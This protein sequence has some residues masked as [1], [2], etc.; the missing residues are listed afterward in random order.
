[1]RDPSRFRDEAVLMLHELLNFD[2]R[3]HFI[4]SKIVPSGTRDL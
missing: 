4:S 1:M 2:V 3:G